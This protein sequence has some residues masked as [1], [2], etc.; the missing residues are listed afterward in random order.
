MTEMTIEEQ[1]LKAFEGMVDMLE[2]GYMPIADD[3]I[4]PKWESFSGCRFIS[5]TLQDGRGVYMEY[6]PR[7]SPI[8]PHF[9]IAPDAATS[10]PGTHVKI[11][12]NAPM[13][14]SMA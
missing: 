2:Q 10:M 7:I 9:Y 1:A 12:N 8:E 5:T 3:G 13:W 4:F 11:V 6:D 14:G